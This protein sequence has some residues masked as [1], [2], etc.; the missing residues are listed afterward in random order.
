MVYI[1]TNIARKTTINSHDNNN[2]ITQQ[3]QYNP[4]RTTIQSEIK[5]LRFC[6]CVRK[7]GNER[8]TENNGGGGRIIFIYF[9]DFKKSTMLHTQLVWDSN[10]NRFCVYFL[11]IE[12][13]SFLHER[14]LFWL[15]VL[16]LSSIFLWTSPRQIF[17][18]NIII[19]LKLSF[20]NILNLMV[21]DRKERKGHKIKKK[22][23]LTNIPIQF[24]FSFTSL[25]IFY[26]T[27]TSTC[28]FH[29]IF[30]HFKV[31]CFFFHKKKTLQ[32]FYFYIKKYY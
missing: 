13:A 30:F 4:I 14:M 26:F 2:P 29:S 16:V 12:T 21:E 22:S 6:N 20:T 28:R 18:A 3:H 27:S 5:C 31:F 17:E 32:N 23:I 7:N 11:H 10:K 1:A 15:L 8:R 9:I 19:T 24:F 25:S